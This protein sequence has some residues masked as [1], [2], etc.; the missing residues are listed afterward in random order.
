MN[1]KEELFSK[2]NIKSLLNLTSQ[3]L[4]ELFEQDIKSKIISVA[5]PQSKIFQCVEDFKEP[6]TDSSIFNALFY[7]QH[8]DLRHNVLL[9]KYIFI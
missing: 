6:L 4:F 8:F 9:K 5:I 2:L 7:I 1:S 3:K